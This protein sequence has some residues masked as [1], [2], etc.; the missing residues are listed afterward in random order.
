MITTISLHHFNRKLDISTK[1]FR[2]YLQTNLIKQYVKANQDKFA[3]DKLVS[4]NIRVYDQKIVK[5]KFAQNFEFS[6]SNVILSP[7]ADFISEALVNVA[8][9]S[10]RQ[11]ANISIARLV[12]EVRKIEIEVIE[13]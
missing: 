7:I 8:Y 4:L 6:G 9:T 2:H 1:V 10:L 3:N 11:I 5:S 12:G 13:L